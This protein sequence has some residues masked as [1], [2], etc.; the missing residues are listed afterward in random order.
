MATRS[1]A[2]G[3]ACAFWASFLCGARLGYD[4][5]MRAGYFATRR[6]ARI[7]PVVQCGGTC[8]AIRLSA[9]PPMNRRHVLLRRNPAAAPRRM[10]WASRRPAARA[11]PGRPRGRRGPP[12]RPLRAGIRRPRV[13]RRKAWVQGPAWP[14]GRALGSGPRYQILSHV[15]ARCFAC[16]SRMS[17]CFLTRATC[18]QV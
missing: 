16:N 4:P 3:S 18:K 12:R 14:G 1:R 15:F 8:P 17:V 10:V 6:R 13:R 5:L 11:G 2:T 9:D 7:P